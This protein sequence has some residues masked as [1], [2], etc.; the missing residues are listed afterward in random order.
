MY[1]IHKVIVKQCETMDG[2]S[3]ISYQTLEL[4]FTY[5]SIFCP[6]AQHASQVRPHLKTFF[7]SDGIMGIL[8]LLEYP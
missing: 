5:L 3:F 6:N 7:L 4:L 2:K 8:L 1:L